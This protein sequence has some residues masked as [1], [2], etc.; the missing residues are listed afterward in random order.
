MAMNKK[1]RKSLFSK[2]VVLLVI[3]LNVAFTRE[4]LK[5]FA[6]TM[7]EPTGLIVAWFSFTT[8]ELWSLAGIKKAEKKKESNYDC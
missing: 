8:A 5:I 6:E 1:K 3:A 4:I 2:F 7:S